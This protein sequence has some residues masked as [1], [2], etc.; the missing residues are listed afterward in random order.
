MVAEALQEADADFLV[1]ALTDFYDV[2]RALPH[3][4]R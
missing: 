1:E 4:P 3:I 2:R